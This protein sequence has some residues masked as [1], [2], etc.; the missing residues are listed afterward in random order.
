MSIEQ[1]TAVV[2]RVVEE[3]VNRGD[4]AAFDALVDPPY[5]DH[6]DP[7]AEFGR[8]GFR[9]LIL[10]TRASLPDMHMTIEDEIAEGDR[11]VIRV[12]TRGTHRGELLGVP[13]TGRPVTLRGT[14][15][16][17]VVD[18]RM[19]ERWNESDLLGVLE[20]LGALPGP[21]AAPA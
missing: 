13:P 17:R 6:T 19:V 8:D 3:I 9:W 4:M 20:Q 14:G 5:R 1:N 2:R 21:E 16:I 7:A 12:T 18:G 15:I 11:V 10:Q